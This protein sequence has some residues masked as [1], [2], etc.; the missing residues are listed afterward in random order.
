M[1][2]LSPMIFLYVILAGMGLGLIGYFILIYNHFIE[3][4]QNT[5]KAWANIDVL[6]KQRHDELAMLSQV[7]MQYAE[8]EQELFSQLNMIRHHCEKARSTQQ[9][10]ELNQ[11][12][13]LLQQ[14]TLQLLGLVERYPALKTNQNYLKAVE[15]ISMLEKIIADRREFYN[16]TVNCYNVRLESFPDVF[17]SKSFGFLPATLLEFK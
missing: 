10:V 12:E 11:Q 16:E 2:A 14:L 4:Y 17:I 1:Q 6:L 3:L 13:T 9:L 8:Y 5:Q 7:V 15:R